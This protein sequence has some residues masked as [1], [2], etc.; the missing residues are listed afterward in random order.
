MVGHGNA[1]YIF[2]LADITI[3]KERRIFISSPFARIILSFSFF[4]S[5]YLFFSF[6]QYT[7]MWALLWIGNKW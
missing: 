2:I 3:K 7:E 1:G 5:F 6:I 4:S